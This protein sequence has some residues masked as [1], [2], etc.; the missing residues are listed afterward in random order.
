MTKA[1]TQVFQIG[2][3]SIEL[4]TRNNHPGVKVWAL[5]NG[6]EIESYDERG[7]RNRVNN[8]ICAPVEVKLKG[9]EIW[10]DAKTK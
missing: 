7:W 6:S 8:R 5:Y 3:W 4:R 1:S 9:E 10:A 2:E